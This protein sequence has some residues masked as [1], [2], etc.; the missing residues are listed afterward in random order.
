[1][2]ITNGNITPVMA[3]KKHIPKFF[4]EA[5]AQSFSTLNPDDTANQTKQEVVNTV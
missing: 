4:L 1:M 3:L 5:I 2:I